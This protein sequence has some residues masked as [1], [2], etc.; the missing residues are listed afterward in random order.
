MTD[1][2]ASGSATLRGKTLHSKLTGQVLARYGAGLFDDAVFSA[3][4]VLELALREALGIP[5]SVEDPLEFVTKAFRPSTGSLQDP[6]RPMSEREG[7]HHL[8]RGTF[9]FYRNPLGHR[10]PNH[11]AEEAYDIIVMINRLLLIVDAAAERNRNM[12]EQVRAIP[13]I[14]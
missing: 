10:F 14:H 5:G 13:E 3:C 6:E 11:D 4:K 7:L 12:A 1:A 2:G 9:M 8:F